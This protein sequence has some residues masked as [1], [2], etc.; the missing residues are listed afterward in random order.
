LKHWGLGFSPS[1]TLAFQIRE[2]RKNLAQV[3]ADGG[4]SGGG[5]AAPV[6]VWAGCE[7][8]AAGE[9]ALVKSSSAGQ[10]QG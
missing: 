5:K 6:T 4:S 3:I 1:H 10:E 9:A 7:N 8:R 2:E